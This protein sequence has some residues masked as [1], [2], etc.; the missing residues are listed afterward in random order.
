MEGVVD[1]SSG[2]RSL[3]GEQGG[4]GGGGTVKAALNEEKTISN[5]KHSSTGQKGGALIKIRAGIE[6][7]TVRYL[8]GSV[9]VVYV[10][11]MFKWGRE[12]RVMIPLLRAITKKSPLQQQQTDRR[13]RDRGRRGEC[14]GR[15]TGRGGEVEG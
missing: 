13:A 12:Y 9:R 2:S 6:A 11:S 15:V 7:R 8:N 4:K 1:E 5:A 3:D 10:F 14:R